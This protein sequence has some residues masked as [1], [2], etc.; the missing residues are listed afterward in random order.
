MGF[1]KSFQK[2]TPDATIAAQAPLK[3]S[4]DGNL[5]YPPSSQQA[6]IMPLTGKALE[7]AQKMSFPD[8]AQEWL[9]LETLEKPKPNLGSAGG[10]LRSRLRVRDAPTPKIFTKAGQSCL[11]SAGDRPRCGHHVPKGPAAMKLPE[12]ALHRVLF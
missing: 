8:K 10:R 1:G 12:A 6:T 7:L 9:D 5:F 2:E 11:E 3:T 4:T